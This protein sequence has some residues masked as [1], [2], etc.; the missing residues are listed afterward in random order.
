[1]SDDDHP[2]KV[3][4]EASAKLTVSTEIPAQASGRIVNA[5]ADVVSPLT[6]WLGLMGDKIRIHRMKVVSDV[7]RRADEYIA[8]G[9]AEPHPIPIKVAVPLLERASQ[10]EVDDDFMIDMWAKLLASTATTSNVSPRFVG[11]IG[12]LNSRQARLLVSLAGTKSIIGPPRSA[13]LQRNIETYVLDALKRAD[14]ADDARDAINA[15]LG[16]LPEVS[17]VSI[18]F[19]ANRPYGMPEFF[20]PGNADPAILASL[21]LLERISI[22]LDTRLP[23]SGHISV[24]Y[25]R[26]TDLAEALLSVTRPSPPRFVV[27]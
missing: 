10:E 20:D 24:R 22:S 19:S 3:N 2:I 14:S 21:G 18:T 16:E 17:D 27:R 11:I 26:I 7:I 12:E 25:H 5:I 6:E 23:D 8:L 9:K 13:S 1:M 4:I 15:Y